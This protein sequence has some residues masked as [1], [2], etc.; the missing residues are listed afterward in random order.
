MS[1]METSSDDTIKLK[2]FILYS[3]DDMAFADEVV[4]GLE[5]NGGFDRPARH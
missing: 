3:R 5:V 2:V 1:R 4:A